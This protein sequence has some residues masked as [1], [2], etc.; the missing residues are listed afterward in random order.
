MTS[1]D[2]TKEVF[3]SVLKKF[4]SIDICVFGTGMHDPSAE[5]NLNTETI[6]R[7]METNFFGT[8]NCIVAVN[9]HFK[10]KK[11]WTNINYFFCCWL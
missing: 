5:K 7:I 4:G 11:K 8:L 3:Q 9:N 1:E 6:R 10:E 2:K